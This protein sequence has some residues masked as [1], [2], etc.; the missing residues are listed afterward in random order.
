MDKAYTPL[1]HK[2]GTQKSA[3]DSAEPKTDQPDKALVSPQPLLEWGSGSPQPQQS[4]WYQP[5]DSVLLLD[6][7]DSLET[8]KLRLLVQGI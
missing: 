5:I 8:R 1:G 3:G 7:P 4:G 6:D 2:R